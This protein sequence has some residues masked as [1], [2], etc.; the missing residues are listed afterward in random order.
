MQSSIPEVQIAIH[1]LLGGV[2]LKECSLTFDTSSKQIIASD[3]FD[4]I[5]VL[6]V[7]SP[8]SKSSSVQLFGD[9]HAVGSEASSKVSKLEAN[10]LAKANQQ[11][12]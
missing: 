7:T 6:N 8:N 3:D 11:S 4:K 2:P 5:S 10:S 9:S 12:G 1:D